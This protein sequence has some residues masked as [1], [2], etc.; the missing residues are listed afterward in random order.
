MVISGKTIQ[1]QI[2]VLLRKERN[3]TI[4]YKT[5]NDL[6]ALSIYNKWVER[7]NFFLF[8]SDTFLFKSAC[9][10]FDTFSWSAF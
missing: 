1:L 2:L 3:G 10:Q 7:G 6:K 8:D 9:R 5:N 4:I